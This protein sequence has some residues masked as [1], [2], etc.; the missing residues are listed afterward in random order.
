M[1][2]WCEGSEVRTVYESLICNEFLEDAHPK[3]PLMPADAYSRARSRLLV[4]RFNTSAVA[5]FYKL[6]MQQDAGVQA[7]CCRTLDVELRWLQ[8]QMHPEGARAGG[9]AALTDVLTMHHAAPS[10]AICALT[11]ADWLK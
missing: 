8:E 10:H 9:E 11:E 7:D 1:L 4:E 2:A 5:T 6:L 3:P